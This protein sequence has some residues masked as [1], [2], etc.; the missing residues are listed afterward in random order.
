SE[1]SMKYPPGFTPKEGTDV[2]GMHTKESDNIVNMS[3]HNAEEELCVKNKENFLALQETKMENMELFSVKM[4]WGN[5]AFDYVH[6][7]SV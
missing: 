6:S 2:V 7:D 3:D 5:F 1:H 4:C